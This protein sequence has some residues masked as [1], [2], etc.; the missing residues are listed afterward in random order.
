MMPVGR[1]RRL[2]LLF[3]ALLALSFS[4]QEAGAGSRVK[5]PV[6]RSTAVRARRNVPRAR[7]YRGPTYVSALVIDAA[8]GRI[9]YQKDP[10][11]L[12]TP[13][14][15][16]KMMLELVAL[17]AIRDGKMRTDE[18]VRVPDEV[19]KIRGSR[20]RLRPGEPVTV[21]DLLEATAIASANDAATALAVR[22]AGSTDACV[23]LM[24]QRA[25]D[26]GMKDTHYENVHGLDRP[27]EPGNV[28]TAWDLGILARHLI[29]MPEVLKIASTVQTTI[30]YG[31]VIHTTNRL[32]GRCEGVDGL[33]TGYTAKAGFCLV[34]TAMRE[35]LRVISIVLGA[36]S[37]GRR[38]S[39][40]AALLEQVYGDWDIVRV[41]SKGQDLGQDMEVR[42]GRSDSVRLVAGEDL[43]VLVPARRAGE[44]RLA[45]TAPPS[46]RA[47][48]ARGWTFGRVQVL[49]GDSVAAEGAAIASGSIRRA[50]IGGVI[51]GIMEALPD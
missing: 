10:H 40:S 12:R 50:G 20:V 7:I 16:S 13:A 31:Q 45:I 26:L 19:R 33:K 2:I 49:V 22:L 24:N 21:G 23:A 42:D 28:T 30:R 17:E 6:R 29:E 32:L 48:V 43:D 44:I 39:E 9:L 35:N 27:G 11:A 3:L 34:S 46:T 1:Q 14:S 18:Y 25:R 36:A 51:D 5:R 8:T 4:F 47:P 37:N 41:V 38:F 15:L